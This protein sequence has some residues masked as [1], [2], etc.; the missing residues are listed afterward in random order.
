MKLSE[1]AQMRMNQRAIS[2]TDVELISNYGNK[3]NRHGC[4]LRICNRK[5]V[6]RML[7]KGVSPQTAERLRGCYIVSNGDALVTVAHCHSRMKRN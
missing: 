5:S 3:L 6:E 1:H 7:A 4:K 2:E